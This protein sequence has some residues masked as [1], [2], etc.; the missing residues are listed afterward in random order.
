MHMQVGEKMSTFRFSSEVLDLTRTLKGD[1]VHLHAVVDLDLFKVIVHFLGMIIYL[2]ISAV[3][4][5]SE[6]QAQFCKRLRIFSLSD[7]VCQNT[8]MFF[9]S[10]AVLEGK[11]RERRK[12]LRN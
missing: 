12:L 4:K 10:P 2:F 11:G 8:S 9:T 5:H 1:R 7:P 6:S 3:K